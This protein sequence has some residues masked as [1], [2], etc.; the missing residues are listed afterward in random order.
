VQE[1]VQPLVVVLPVQPVDG[2]LDQ[3]QLAI[4]GEGLVQPV[5]GHHV[6]VQRSDVDLAVVPQAQGAVG[7]LVN[8][9]AED[10]TATF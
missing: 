10:D 7:V 3:V 5:L 8:G 4:V 2:G 1:E 9:G 6:V